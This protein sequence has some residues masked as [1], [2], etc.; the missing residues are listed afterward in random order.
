MFEALRRVHL[1]PSE[2]TLE[3]DVHTVNENVFR[4]LDSSV[5][6]GGE[7]FS[8]GEKQL[9]CMAR[10]ILK[11]SKVLVMDEATASVDYATDE[12]IGKTI[13]Q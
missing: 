13:R 5:S 10:A 7:N 1:I 9:L 12:L 4:N 11:R 6:E 8:T 3:Q 2:G